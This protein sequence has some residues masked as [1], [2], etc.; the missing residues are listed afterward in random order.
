MNSM[1]SVKNRGTL[2][3]V[4]RSGGG[5]GTS[6]YDELQNRPKINNKIVTG[7]QSG[8]YYDLAEINDVIIKELNPEIQAGV[9]YPRLEH[10]KDKDD[11]IY[12][13]TYNEFTGGL[14]GLVPSVLQPSGKVL[15]DSGNWVN[16]SFSYTYDLLWDYERDNNNVID[17]GSYTHNLQHSIDDYK[18]LIIKFSSTRNDTTSARW[19]QCTECYIDVYVLTHGYRPYRLTYTSFGDRASA[20]WFDVVNEHNQVRIECEDT[21]VNGMTQIYGIK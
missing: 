4:V 11:N 12:K 14:S 18:Y 16:M 17:Y 9:N 6:D 5:G 13:L 19:N 3:G 8:H 10:I 2:H 20:I 21:N 1:S 15:T 7:A